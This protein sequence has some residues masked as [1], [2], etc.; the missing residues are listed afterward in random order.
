MIEDSALTPTERRFWKLVD[1]KREPD[2]TPDFEACWPWKGTRTRPS[3]RHQSHPGYGQFFLKRDDKG[4]A[5]RVRAH[6]FAWE[7]WNGEPMPKEFD[8][9]HATCDNPP[10][11]NPT[12]IQPEPHEDNWRAY[13]V[14]YYGPREG[15]A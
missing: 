12:H 1:V 7:C 15:A 6:R 9:A 14:K 2:G 11:C 10:C 4:R 5:I 13:V 3:P 8:A